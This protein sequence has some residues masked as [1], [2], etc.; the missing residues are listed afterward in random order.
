M[1]EIENQGRAAALETKLA[2]IAEMIE[3]TNQRLTHIDEDSEFNEMDKN[4]VKDVR[5]QLKELEK[6]QSKLQKEYGK[7]GKMGLPKDYDED[8]QRS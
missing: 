4:K 1:K 7:M 5:K 3:E 6:A 8:T 2:A